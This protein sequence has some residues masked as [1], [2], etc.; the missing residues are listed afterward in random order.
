VANIKAEL[1]QQQPQTGKEE[2][3]SVGGL[4]TWRGG[5]NG[6]EL[7]VE[8]YEACANQVSV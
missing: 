2:A 5:Y 1:Q 8:E 4:G 7:P 3:A 6:Q